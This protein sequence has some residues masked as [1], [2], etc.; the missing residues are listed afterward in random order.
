MEN[1]IEVTKCNEKCLINVNSILCV[2]PI[3]KNDENIISEITNSEETQE[4]FD[5][6]DLLGDDLK[7]KIA[8]ERE[9]VE[10]ANTIIELAGF[11]KE[12]NKAL[13]V[14]ETYDE[15]KNMIKDSL[16]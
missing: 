11:D 7:E 1:F 9:E 2:A 13:F 10:N 6:F 14:Q 5:L 12:N 16:A 8:K 15:I 4:L 3:T